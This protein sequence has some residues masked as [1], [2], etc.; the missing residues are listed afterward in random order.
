LAKKEIYPNLWFLFRDGLLPELTFFVGYARSKIKIKEYLKETIV[1]YM[2]VSGEEQQKYDEFVSLNYYLSG[3]YDKKEAFQ[4]LNEKI[5]EILKEIQK[6]KYNGDCNRILYLALPPS[7]YTSVTQL[8]SENCRAKRY[9]NNSDR[10]L[11]H[12]C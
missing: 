7:V 5:K 12:P 9:L 10:S 4:E 1:Q 6:E 2:Q 3:L 11:S 8:L